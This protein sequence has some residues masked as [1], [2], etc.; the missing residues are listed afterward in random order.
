MS[1][2][3]LACVSVSTFP[4]EINLNEATRAHFNTSMQYNG[5]QLLS[6]ISDTA[7]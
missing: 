5:F 1:R 7:S 4:V 6:Q 2:E 3:C